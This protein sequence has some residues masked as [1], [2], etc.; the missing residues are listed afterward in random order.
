MRFQ[1]DD[2]SF[3]ERITWEAEQ[4][5]HIEG[6]DAMGGSL[7]PTFIVMHYTAGLTTESAVQTFCAPQSKVS[8]HLVIG[9]E[10]DVVQCVPFN[11][12]AWHAGRSKWGNVI[13]LNR[14]SIGIEL[15]SAGKLDRQGSHWVTWFG[16][17]IDPDEVFVDHAGHGWHA[18]TEL[19]IETA[20]TVCQDLMAVYDI[21]DI[22]GHEE[23]SPGR[24]IDPGPALRLSSFKASVMG[25]GSEGGEDDMFIVTRPIA[26][27]TRPHAAS[28]QVDVPLSVDTIV[29]AE[30]E[31]PG[32]MHVCVEV[33]E[34]QLA[35][36]LSGWVR[37][38]ALEPYDPADVQ[39][40]MTDIQR[41]LDDEDWEERAF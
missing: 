24:K 38:N 26:I 2:Q 7:D 36:P 41:Y 30:D 11:R 10:G 29:V 32:W 35:D 28:D 37:R 14:A 33:F 27:H 13:G 8:A 19:Q 40:V 12:Q 17:R 3:F 34:G 22:L 1:I 5:F 18:Y 21:Q 4:S 20:R 6:S 31:V 9:R 25:A 15:V 23:V 16:K 39:L